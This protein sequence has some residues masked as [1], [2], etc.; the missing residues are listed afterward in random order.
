MGYS[1]LM[2]DYHLTQ[3]AVAKSVGKD[4]STIAN[5]LR[6]LKLP[7]M[8]MDFIREKKLSF[9]HAKVLAGTSDENLIISMAKETVDKNLSVRE[10]EKLAK[11][12][13]RSKEK[14]KDKENNPSA[15]RFAEYR[16]K[17]EQKTGFHCNVKA[18]G[19]SGYI[20]LKFSGESEF[21]DIYEFLMKQ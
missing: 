4:R 6:I 11:G 20:L 21:N 5:Y 17:L 16:E 13:V 1:T 18:K 14:Q 7:R 10:L 19:A 2:N 3:E 9:G 12:V 15:E 8:V